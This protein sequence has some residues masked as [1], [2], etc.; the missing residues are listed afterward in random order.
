MNIKIFF[1]LV[2]LL[3]S[4]TMI[5]AASSSE[6]V[7]PIVE[8]VNKT[9]SNSVIV[10]EILPIIPQQKISEVIL[11]SDEFTIFKQK[12]AGDYILLTVVSFKDNKFLIDFYKMLLSFH[13][14]T[15]GEFAFYSLDNKLIL[16][17]ISIT[18]NNEEKIDLNHDNSEDIILGYLGYDVN[19]LAAFKVKAYLPDG[20]LYHNGHY[21]E[22][23]QNK[24]KYKCYKEDPET[25]N[26]A[27]TYEISSADLQL[28]GSTIE[29]K[30]QDIV[31]KEAIDKQ[32]QNLNITTPKNITVTQI[33]NE[34]TTIPWLKIGLLGIIVLI[35]I[36]IGYL[37]HKLIKKKIE[38]NN[39][40]G[41]HY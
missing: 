33:G 41:G 32:N 31:Q 16:S 10:T 24:E 4:N 37:K 29:Q 8:I 36:I 25:G 6:I 1:G 18:K 14:E 30:V 19:N 7:F 3:L 12:Q 27:E 20:I 38:E 15:S 22:L 17:S 35:I 13:S 40:Y 26:V 23:E 9:E 34:K 28:A 21:C 39:D 2:F 5:L 11:K